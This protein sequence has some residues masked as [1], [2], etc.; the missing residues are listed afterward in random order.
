LARSD[1]GSS[2]VVAKNRKMAF[3]GIC[4]T[5]WRPLLARSAIR[6]GGKRSAEVCAFVKHDR[7]VPQLRQSS[8]GQPS[9]IEPPFNDQIPSFDEEL[10]PWE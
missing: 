1:L 10:I 8:Q 7:T 5:A 4:R 2:F 6:D 9:E 3:G